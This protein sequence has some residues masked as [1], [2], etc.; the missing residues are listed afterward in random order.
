MLSQDSTENEEDSFISSLANLGLD[1]LQM[2]PS[3]MKREIELI[4]QQIQSLSLEH[5]NVFIEN[6]DCVRFVKQK[7]DD[8]S[9][10]LGTLRKELDGLK[11]EAAKFQQE[12][13]T[14]LAA[15]KRNGHTAQQHMQL[16]E[17]LEV[18]QLMDACARNG[19][20]E[21]ALAVARFAEQLNRRHHPNLRNIPTAL[22]A[23]PPSENGAHSSETKEMQAQRL[24]DGGAGV[25]G[26][27]VKEVRA[28]TLTL[29]K[30]MLQQLKSQLPLATCLQ[31]ISCL[32]RLDTLEL[33]RRQYESGGASK[34]QQACS[35]KDQVLLELQL[36]VEFLEARDAWLQASL[37]KLDQAVG[38]AVQRE[39][40]KVPSNP[41][42]HLTDRIE[43]HRALWFEITTQFN[44]LF[45]GD[46]YAPA[47]LACWLNRRVDMFLSELAEGLH[48]ILEMGAGGGESLRGILDQAMV[49]AAA[50]GRSS[51][52]DFRG[53]IAP[54][55]EDAVAQ[56]CQ[57]QW[58]VA[59]QALCADIKDAYKKGQE[60][61]RHRPNTL[62]LYVPSGHWLKKEQ[63]RSVNKEEE[64]SGLEPPPITLCN[65][66][67]LAQFLNTILTSFNQLRHCTP[68]LLQ[69]RLKEA[70]LSAMN[71]V[72]EELVAFRHH[73]LQTGSELDKA[74]ST[75]DNTE[76]GAAQV[77]ELLSEAFAVDASPYICKC[78]A[79][80]FSSDVQSR[81]LLQQN[82]QDEVCQQIKTSGVY[83]FVPPDQD[84]EEPLEHEQKM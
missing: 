8:M 10:H 81:A 58:N 83:M 52:A 48:V 26:I 3:R 73:L 45:G 42:Q 77:L 69:K 57:E 72:L 7:S 16:V 84:Y 24:S 12:A 5:Y 79:V 78:F 39:N 49:F 31:L 2:E 54:I 28:S 21:E 35:E 65:F 43:T 20:Y 13:S 71:L 50:M 41:Y 25:I 18:P 75:P 23:K 38:I 66:P 44:S 46:Q 63:S 6:Q 68:L 27:I 30:K 56:K 70:L 74:E 11:D 40:R 9:V 22:V 1:R 55:F 17:L 67:A 4:E 32:R 80:L 59:C 82:F 19:L 61:D 33:E 14:A 34:G 76:T 62:P 36:Q 37:D 15:H 29:R 53:R 64:K 51:G 47:V 60:K